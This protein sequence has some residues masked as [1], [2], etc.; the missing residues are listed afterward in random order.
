MSERWSP[1][2]AV[3]FWVACSLAFWIGA[4]CTTLFAFALDQLPAY[5]SADRVRFV[6]YPGGHMFYSRD[7]SRKA[8]RA[9]VIKPLSLTSK[10]FGMEVEI[11]AMVCK[12]RA[13]TYEVPISYYGRAYEEGKKIG[14]RDWFIALRTFWRY[15]RSGTA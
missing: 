8:F 4:A 15:R 11:T 14:L 5:A 12:T 1:R 6:V 7:G 9:E 10:G 2:R 3:A 13:R